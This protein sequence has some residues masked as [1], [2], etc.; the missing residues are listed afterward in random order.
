[1]SFDYTTP[2]THIFKNDT[3]FP[4]QEIEFAGRKM[5]CPNNM[6][7]YLPSLYGSEYMIPKKT[8]L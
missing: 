6:G 7:K 4:L 3:L 2:T 1:M 8:E 5:K